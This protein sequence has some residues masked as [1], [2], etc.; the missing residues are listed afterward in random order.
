MLNIPGHKGNANQNSIS[1]LLQWLLP[2]TQ[3]TTN[4]EEDLGKMEPSF[5]DFERFSESSFLNL[6]TYQE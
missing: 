5:A 6:Q 1:F 3:T 4:V 2:R